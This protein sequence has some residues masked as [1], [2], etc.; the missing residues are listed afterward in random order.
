MIND[1]PGSLANESRMVKQIVTKQ[2][3]ALTVFGR[4]QQE[5]RRKT[6]RGQGVIEY[7][8]ALVIAAVIIAA[9]IIV[10]P[11]GFANMMNTIYS[12]VGDYLNGEVT[13]L[14]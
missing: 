3:R 1:Y 4:P 13:E 10:V 6:P 14:G 11:P 12:S 5:E 7:A 8:G 9:G 2:V